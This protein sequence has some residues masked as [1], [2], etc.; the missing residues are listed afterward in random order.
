LGLA[1]LVNSLLIDD[2]SADEATELQQCVPIPAVPGEA[3]RFDRYNCADTP[4]ANRS[5]QLLKPGS[6]NT[7]PGTAQIV[8]NHFD[9]GPAEDVSALDQPIFGAVGFQDCS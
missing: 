9:G 8:V 1:G 4:L 3:R 7:R 5:E 6:R 2:Q